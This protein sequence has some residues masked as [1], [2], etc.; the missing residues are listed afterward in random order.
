L[1]TLLP[2]FSSDVEG[3]C[4]S[5]GDE[6][7]EEHQDSLSDQHHFHPHL[8]LETSIQAPPARQ[9]HVPIRSPLPPASRA[10]PSSTNNFPWLLPSPD[11][12]NRKVLT[13]THLQLQPA[14]Q[15]LLNSSSPFLNVDL[16]RVTLPR[17]SLDSPTRK[18]AIHKPRSSGYSKNKFSD[19]T[20]F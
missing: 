1:T 5:S 18:L 6:N 4:S 16:L 12:P 19:S 20:W 14:K 15:T 3:T 10:P 11:E 17:S 7:D 13:T 2:L 8:S 9:N